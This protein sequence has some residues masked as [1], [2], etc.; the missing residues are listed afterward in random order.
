MPLLHNRK[1]GEMYAYGNYENRNDDPGDRSYLNERRSRIKKIKSILKDIAKDDDK[2][3]KNYAS[4]IANIFQNYQRDYYFQDN[5]IIKEVISF[6]SEII[7]DCTES[8]I[9]YVT[10][11]NKIW[12]RTSDDTWVKESESGEQ[13]NY[14]RDVFKGVNQECHTSE[15]DRGWPVK[16]TGTEY[17]IKLGEEQMSVVEEGGRRRKTRR[18][19]RRR[20][21]RKTNKRR[22]KNV[23]II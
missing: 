1:K 14:I 17:E 5:K 4:K 3:Y 10:A 19:T 7:N 8:C 22:K 20:R 12:A 9:T 18:K 23:R 16:C 6:L 13:R 15:T 21:Q 11:F 2:P